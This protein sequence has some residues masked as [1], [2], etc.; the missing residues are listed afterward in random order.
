MIR[1]VRA[2]D[3]TT[4]VNPPVRSDPGLPLGGDAA[5]TPDH[6]WFDK[7]E[8]A[9]FT[10]NK[11]VQPRL[12]TTRSLAPLTVDQEVGGSSPPSCTSITYCKIRTNW[13]SLP[14]SRERNI[15]WVST[16][17]ALVE[18]S[19]DHASRASVV[20]RQLPDSKQA[21]DQVRLDPVLNQMAGSGL[22]RAGGVV[23]C[24]RSVAA[25]R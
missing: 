19:P 10:D 23:R 9:F 4:H 6:S 3:L 12:A 8:S 7:R 20:V 21:D 24:R 13:P 25:H 16:G 14:T 2:Y 15:I 1:G 22:H 17:S 11:S 5:R 18:N